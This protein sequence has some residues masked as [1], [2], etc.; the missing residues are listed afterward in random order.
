MWDT[1]YICTFMYIFTYIYLYIYMYMYIVRRKERA[2]ESERE[3]ERTKRDFT[4]AAGVMTRY[5]CG[6]QTVIRQWGS[7]WIGSC[8][9]HGLLKS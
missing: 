2:R 7:S 4:R 9:L 5:M 6:I 1:H 3:R 8:I